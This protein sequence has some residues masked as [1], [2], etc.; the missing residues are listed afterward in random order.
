M[1]VRNR[2]Y[3]M[4]FVVD[5]LDQAMQRWTTMTGA[6]PWFVIPHFAF[7]DPVLRGRPAAPDISIALA[8]SGEVMLEL[9]R[10]ESDAPSVFHEAPPAPGALHHVAQLTEDFESTMAA[11]A[12]SEAPAVFTARFTP[13]TRAAFVDTRAAIGCWTEIIEAT[14]PL[15][16]MQQFM[17]TATDGWDGKT[18]WKRSFG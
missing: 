8:Y 13:E 5:D 12:A 2:I 1:A 3:Q 15:L 11:F 7:I 4:A 17:R 14:P 16:G 9:I 10:R 6:G 18:D